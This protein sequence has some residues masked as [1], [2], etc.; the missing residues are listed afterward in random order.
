MN[1]WFS[2][3]REAYKKKYNV[4]RVVC[5]CVCVCVCVYRLSGCPLRELASLMP[6]EQA[7]QTP[8]SQ[9][10]NTILH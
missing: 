4:I 7:N 10:L 5:L 2:I 9:F 8:S 6:Q 3:C 1:S